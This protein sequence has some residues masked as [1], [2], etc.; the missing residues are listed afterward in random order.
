MA[1]TST[2]WARGHVRDH[3]PVFMLTESW[4][5][6]LPLALST[7]TATAADTVAPRWSG[8]L[9][10]ERVTRTAALGPSSGTSRPVAFAK[11]R[12]WPATESEGVLP[13]RIVRRDLNRHLGARHHLSLPD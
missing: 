13:I 8:D 12:R 10:S 3:R 4:A 6:P 1:A 9:D 11:V 7:L 2:H 5:W